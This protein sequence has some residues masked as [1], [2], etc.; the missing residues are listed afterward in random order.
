[1]RRARD[2]GGARVQRRELAR[3][4]PS[5]APAGP[6]SRSGPS[7]ATTSVW[8]RAASTSSRM[9]F[10]RD[11]RPGEEDL[12]RL[13]LL[14]D[15]L[16]QLDAVRD[17][18][19]VARAEAAHVLRERVRHREHD[20]RF[21]GGSRARAVARAARARGRCRAR[22]ARR[23]AASRA[24]RPRS[25]ASARARRPRRVPPAGRRARTRRGRAA[26]RAR[27][28]AAGAG[29]RRR[30]RRTRSR[31]A[32]TTPATRPRLSTPRARSRSTAS[33]TNRPAASP[34]KRGYDVVRTTTFTRARARA[35]RARRRAP[36][37]RCARARRRAS[38]TASSPRFQRPCSSTSAA[39]SASTSSAGAT[40]PA[41]ISSISRRGRAVRRHRGEDRPLRPRRTRTPCPG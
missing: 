12:R 37:A 22:S 27:A 5:R 21:A 19:H 6:R 28:T 20:A 8:P 25:A 4:A 9:P 15:L 35:R 31:S 38:S 30:R 32:G 2:D 7:P 24:R 18:A 36:G 23:G 40:M 29:S 16:R 10:S 11:S 39:R 1:M 3:A 34:A 33:A 26:A 14:A 41:P 17:D 13:R